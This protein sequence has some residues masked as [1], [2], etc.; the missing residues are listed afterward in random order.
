M[1]VASL[2]R[3]PT[4]SSSL[5]QN[6]VK[7]RDNEGIQSREVPWI[8]QVISDVELKLLLVA[9]YLIFLKP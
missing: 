7:A 2:H 5:K 3:P 1:R 4:R 9:E 8:V 6:Y